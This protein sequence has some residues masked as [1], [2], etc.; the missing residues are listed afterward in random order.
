MTWKH[1]PHEWMLCNKRWTRFRDNSIFNRRNLH[2]S[3]RILDTDTRTSIDNQQATTEIQHTSIDSNN[4]ASIDEKN[5]APYDSIKDEIFNSIKMDNQW[6]EDAV[7]KKL[8]VF[9]CRLNNNLNWET[10]RRELLQKE[11]DLFRN[12]KEKH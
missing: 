3:I 2:R 5:P 9:Y 8:D 10:K 1:Y 7:K 12:K 6:E 11:L 4:T